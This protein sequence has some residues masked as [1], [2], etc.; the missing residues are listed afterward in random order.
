MNGFAILAGW[1]VIGAIALFFKV[2]TPAE[3]DEWSR[4]GL[5]AIVIG[6]VLVTAIKVLGLIF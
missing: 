4:I 5:G 1:A 3:R 2:T 6:G